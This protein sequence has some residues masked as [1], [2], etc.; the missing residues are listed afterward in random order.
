MLSDKF[1]PKIP[2]AIGFLLLIFSFI[3]TAFFVESSIGVL[4]LGLLAFGFGIPLV[5]TP[6]YASAMGA[7]PQT[8][9]GSAFG[10]IATIRSLSATLGVAVLGA[11]IDTTQL[12]SLQK[13]AQENPATKTLDPSLLENIIAG[14][15]LAK[16]YLQTLST[17]QSQII[18][19]YYRESQVQS[20]FYT[21]LVLAGLLVIS[22]ILVFM[23]YHRKS[24]HQLPEAPAE[25]WD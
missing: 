2:I 23:L 20:F 8:K 9:A 18:L 19:N 22:L 21:H 1:G 13:F 16:E 14:A 7:I 10:T 24:A 25:G 5:F 11:F 6:S 15:Q 17:Q 3:W 12:K 4:F